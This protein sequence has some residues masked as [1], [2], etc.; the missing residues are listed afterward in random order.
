MAW[1][2]V[3]G[4]WW[5]C[6]GIRWWM[7]QPGPGIQHFYSTLTAP[8]TLETFRFL[9]RKVWNSVFVVC[10]LYCD[11]VKSTLFSN[12]ILFEEKS[13]LLRRGEMWAQLS[14]EKVTVF[15][16]ENGIKW[17]VL[18]VEKLL[19]RLE[20]AMEIVK[21]PKYWG[22]LV[23][24]YCMQWPLWPGPGLTIDCCAIFWL[25][26]SNKIP[27]RGLWLISLVAARASNEGPHKGS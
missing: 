3:C 16:A 27:G 8:R 19:W 6:D 10:W 9:S 4:V 25:I 13:D 11:A 21:I 23:M 5:R 24:V 18:F 17:N 26:T 15:C 12:F 2:W 22:H 1:C 14:W 20:T 7:V